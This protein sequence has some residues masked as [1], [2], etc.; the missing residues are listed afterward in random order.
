MLYLWQILD[1]GF[2]RGFIFMDVMTVVKAPSLASLRNGEAYDNNKTNYDAY[3][4]D[5]VTI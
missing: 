2:L 4:S 3:S 5:D 1:A